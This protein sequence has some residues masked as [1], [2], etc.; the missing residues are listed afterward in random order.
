MQVSGL[1]QGLAPVPVVPVL[2]LAQVQELAPV[3]VREL[4]QVQELGLDSQ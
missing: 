1:A 2:V 4:A 3:Q